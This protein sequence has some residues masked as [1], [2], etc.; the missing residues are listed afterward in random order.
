MKRFVLGLVSAMLLACGG[1]LLAQDAPPPTAV[2][3]APPPSGTLGDGPWEIET[4]ATKLKVSVVTK[5]LQVPWSLAFLPNGDMLVTE[6]PGRLRLVR[7]GGALDPTPIAGLPA[8]LATGIGGLKDIALHPQFAR[9]RLLYLSY[10]KP[11]PA[12]K[13][14]STLAVLRARWNGGPTLTEVKDIFVAD[15]WYGGA[16]IPARCCGQGPPV[17]SFGG[18]ILFDRAGYLYITSGDRNYGE[19]V[20]D[21]SNHFGKI[22]RLHDD[23][24]A[25]KDN[26][27]A[28]KAGYKPEIYTIGHRNP[29]G[30]TIHPKTKALWSSEFGPR[31]GDEVNRIEAGKN[32]GWINVTQGFHYNN[33][34]AKGTKGVAGMEDPVLAFGPPSINPGNL[35]FYTGKRFKGWNGDMLMAT[36]SRSIVRASFDRQGKPIGQELMLT[37]LKQRF[38]DIRLGPDGNFYI[39]TD[40]RFGAL[41]KVEPAK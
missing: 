23:G 27:F 19:K 8:I 15:A 39:L 29:L 7:K 4:Q 33:E 13:D 12:V 35:L 40:E 25:P 38:R 16:P 5:G 18:R 26:P 37:Q 2:P 3:T 9:N 24:R 11:D 17:G 1:P 10:T 14:Q 22:L 41:L 21:P 34:P 32:Y 28:G 31:G 36:M 20:Q 6:R 30:L